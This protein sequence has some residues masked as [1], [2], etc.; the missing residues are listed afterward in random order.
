MA[1]TRWCFTV[2]NHTDDD[3]IGLISLS[4][5]TDPATARFLI[6]QEEKGSTGTP[7]LQGYIELRKRKRLGGVKALTGLERAHIE[8]AKGDANANIAY[9]TKP[10]YERQWRYGTPVVQGQRTDLRTLKADLDAGMDLPDIWD[11]HF[12]TMVMYNRGISS[13]L[14]LRMGVRSS[15]PTVIVH[16]GAAGTGKSRAAFQYAEDNKMDVYTPVAPNGSKTLWWDG[17]RQQPV[18]VLDDFYGWINWS[19]LLRLLD[20]YPMAVQGKGSSV[21]F[22]SPVIF[23]TSNAPPE[24]W[25][26][27]APGRDKNA[28]YRRL[29]EVREFGLS[30]PLG[31]LKS[32]DRTKHYHDPLNSPELRERYE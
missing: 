11:A 1:S 32:T 6:F 20:R 24:S 5:D 21:Q 30:I 10:P 2:N 8:Q 25:Y 28:L 22:D 14:D 26:T 29:G 31:V 27:Q 3:V 23:I 15:R 12:K 7:H 4:C 19:T 13:Y 18:V 17:Y 16:F 9:C